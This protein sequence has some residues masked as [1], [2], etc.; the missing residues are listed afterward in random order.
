MKYL[1]RIAIIKYS[2]QFFV[3]ADNEDEAKETA[4]TY[5]QENM[6]SPDAVE[7]DETQEDTLETEII[8]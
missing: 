2:E 4:V 8:I 3:E 7:V 5:F 6:F 1:V